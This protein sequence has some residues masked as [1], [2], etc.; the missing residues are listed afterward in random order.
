MAVPMM[1]KQVHERARKK[2]QPD[3][4]AKHMCAM[5]GK[6][7]RTSDDQE[8]DQHQRGPRLDGWA[9]PLGFL[10]SKMILHRHRH[11]P[12]L[13]IRS[14]PDGPIDPKSFR[15]SSRTPE[16]FHDELA[17]EHA[18]RAG[19]AELAGCSWQQL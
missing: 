10:I 4:K 1:H 18:H 13:N 9:R 16:L 2:G 6:Q 15:L 17:A 14:A 3:E 12:C 7:Q 19:K 5:L 8:S 11:T